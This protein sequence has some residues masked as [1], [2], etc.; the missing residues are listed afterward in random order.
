MSRARSESRERVADPFSR[1]DP[2]ITGD[3]TSL[4]P[5]PTGAIAAF[6]GIL[7]QPPLTGL[8]PMDGRDIQGIADGTRHAPTAQ[9]QIKPRK[10]LLPRGQ[11]PQYDRATQ[12]LLD[13]QRQSAQN[14]ALM[15][16]NMAVYSG[17]AFPAPVISSARSSLHM[18]QN[19]LDVVPPGRLGY[20][21]RPSGLRGEFLIHEDHAQDQF[22]ATGYA[23]FGGSNS[24]SRVPSR[25]PSIGQGHFS[26]PGSRISSRQPSPDHLD[27]QLNGIG[28][29]ILNRAVSPVF[30]RSA[31]SHDGLR[32]IDMRDGDHVADERVDNLAVSREVPLE[33]NQEV[34]NSFSQPS[35][36]TH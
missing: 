5:V 11:P 24:G 36:Y 22:N 10:Q 16:Q 2:S 30:R 34:N 29:H 6:T 28:S 4:L 19:G 21:G 27:A 15:Q 23:A 9:E 1:N 7:R 14:I 31:L 3:H 20:G 12:E 17:G 25:A 35:A 33:L 32:E 13:R 8:P 18:G 26:A